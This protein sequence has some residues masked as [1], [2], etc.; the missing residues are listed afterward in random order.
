LVY[1]GYCENPYSKIILSVILARMKIEGA[2]YWDFME[3]AAQEIL[4][5]LITG[6]IRNKEMPLNTFI[7]V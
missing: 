2:I 3:A 5:C 4:H 1:V 7:F 6:I